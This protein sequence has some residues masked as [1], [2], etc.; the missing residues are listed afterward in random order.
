M[1]DMGLYSASFMKS[2]NV[3]A[4]VCGEILESC[5]IFQAIARVSVAFNRSS[6][7]ASARL[8]KWLWSGKMLVFMDALPFVLTLLVSAYRFP[9]PIRYL[10]PKRDELIYVVYGEEDFIKS[11]LHFKD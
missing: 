2:A 6:C 10:Q 11:N 1:A 4:K 8:Y 5:L 3:Y 9:H 7:F